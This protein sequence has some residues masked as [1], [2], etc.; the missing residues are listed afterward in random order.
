MQYNYNW[1]K[2]G[3]V[4]LAPARSAERAFYDGN[5]NQYSSC[6]C[7]SLYTSLSL[8][9]YIYI[10]MRVYLYAAYIYIYIEREREREMFDTPSWLCAPSSL[11]LKICHPR[12]C[13]M[14]VLVRSIFKLR[15]SEF[16]VWVKRILEQRRCV[17]LA[18]RLM[19]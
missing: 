18:H 10:Y 17:F 5:D 2:L 8:S 19:S 13:P 12:D 9:L 16:G 7:C 11:T 1:I 14:G 15:I 4:A 6:I 3:L